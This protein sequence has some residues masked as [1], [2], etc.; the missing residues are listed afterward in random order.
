MSLILLSLHPHGSKWPASFGREGSAIVL[1]EAEAD[2]SGAYEG[3]NWAC[4]LL[5][6]F[7]SDPKHPVILLCCVWE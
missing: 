2:F 7:I 6:P 3:Q 5:L 4:A 1:V